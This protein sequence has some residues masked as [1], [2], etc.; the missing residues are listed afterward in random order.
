MS[1]PIL[2]ADYA[3][4]EARIVCWLADEQAALQ[5]YRDGVD[6]YK[7]M[8]S[9]I[10]NVPVEEV[11]KHP[12][13]F[14]GK[15]AILLSGFQGGPGAFR[16]G[17]AKF[18]YKDMPPG[19][20]DLA[21]NKFRAKHPKLKAYWYDTENAAQR[22]IANKG[23]V[24]RVVNQRWEY[25]VNISFLHEDVNGLPFLLMRLPS[26]RKLAYPQP[27]LAPSPKFEGKLEIRFFGHIVGQQWG[28]VSTYGGKLV[29]NAT[30]AVAA[31]IMCQGA[32]NAEN[33]GFEIMALIHDQ[34]LAYGTQ[35]KTSERF[36]ECLT[37]LPLWADGLPIDAEGGLVP[38]YK[39]D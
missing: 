22:A 32:H 11:N 8:A 23:R 39:K 25:P 3:A 5:E 15:Q 19:L 35:G 13:R 24:F 29:E 17:C 2:D 9:D 6:R 21:V 18:G 36:V 31:D 20:E 4:I 28:T 38:F 1:R 37:D 10:Y 33:D 7:V 34:A 14:I 12:Q 27:R 26:G 16:R 30:Q